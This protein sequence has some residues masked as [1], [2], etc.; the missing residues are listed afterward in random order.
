MEEGQPGVASGELLLFQLVVDM[1]A[2]DAAARL[3]V[4]RAHVQGRPGSPQAKHELE[5]L[6]THSELWRIITPVSAALLGLGGKAVNLAALMK[7]SGDR[8]SLMLPGSYSDNKQQQPEVPSH[9]IPPFPLLHWLTS[10][11]SVRYA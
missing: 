8:A 1:L 11:F 6:L 3:A 2:Q 4:F 7:G 9:E 5:S 10:S